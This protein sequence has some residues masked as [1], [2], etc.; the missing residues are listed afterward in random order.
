MFIRLNYFVD[1]DNDEYLA[2]H[3]R[4]IN[5]ECSICM[6]PIVNEVQLIC[7]HS[8]CGA[9][10]LF[11]AEKEYKGKIIECPLC[12][13]RS[14]LLITKF[15][16]N[17]DNKEILEK[18]VL[19]NYELVKLHTNSLCFCID[20]YRFLNYYIRQVLNFNNYEYQNHRMIIACT[21]FVF[22]CLLTYPL[23]YEGEI[24][25]VAMD[26]VLYFIII[27]VIVEKF[28]RTIRLQTEE[29][30]ERRN[31]ERNLGRELVNI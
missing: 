11:W 5:E 7:S 4:K 16:E 29:I 31:F 27:I 10:I 26:V 25:K 28:Y 3:T 9:C 22:L 6:E 18:V 8:F 14:K 13:K 2:K 21:T 23:G 20:S 15:S 19:Y 17:K 1:K 24:Y 12:R 30:L